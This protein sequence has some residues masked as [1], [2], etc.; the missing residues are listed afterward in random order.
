MPLRGRYIAH[1]Q[2]KQLKWKSTSERKQNWKTDCSNQ[3]ILD[4]VLNLIQPASSHFNPFQL[5]KGISTHSG[6]LARRMAGL[7]YSLNFSIKKAFLDIPLHDEGI[8]QATIV[9]ED[10]R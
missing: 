5:A 4:F 6:V 1:A 3:A 2:T 10:S 7:C 9:E 8:P